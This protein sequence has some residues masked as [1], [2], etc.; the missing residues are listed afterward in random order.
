MFRNHLCSFDFE[1]KIQ[2]VNEN[3]EPALKSFNKALDGATRNGGLFRQNDGSGLL[4]LLVGNSQ[5]SSKP[6]APTTRKPL[7]GNLDVDYDI[8]EDPFAWRINGWRS[9]WPNLVPDRTAQL[10]P[11]AYTSHSVRLARGESSSLW[12]MKF[13][14]LA[15]KLFPTATLYLCSK[16]F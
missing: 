13:D 1:W 6:L 16:L 8:P 4:G 14:S 12:S 3:I 10:Q 7:T 15:I 9:R 11:V 2:R 5:P